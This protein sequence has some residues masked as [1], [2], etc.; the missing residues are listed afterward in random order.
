MLFV[1]SWIRY[2]L[3]ASSTRTNAIAIDLLTPWSG[4]LLETPTGSQL[5]KKFPAFYGIWKFIVLFTRARHL[6]LS[7]ASSIQSIPSHPTSWRYISIYLRK[8]NN[9][10]TF[11]YKF[12][13][14]KLSS[15]CFKQ[16]TLHHQDF[17]T[18]SLQ[19]F[20]VN[21]YEESSRRHNKI[22]RASD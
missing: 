14:I 19:Y 1:W 20:T 7:W 5:L 16:I 10:H 17:C 9:R 13:S 2:D 21:L 11:S 6:S 22:Y 18:S 3:M 8:T 15:T 12:I 4:A